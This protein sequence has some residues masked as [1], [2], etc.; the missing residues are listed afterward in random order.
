LGKRSAAD[1]DVPTGGINEWNADPEPFVWTK[2][3][4][5]ILETLAGCCQRIAESRQ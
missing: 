5:Q 2:T 4:D 1:P 3:A